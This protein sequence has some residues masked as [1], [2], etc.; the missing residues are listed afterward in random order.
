MN[1]F[2]V[3]FTICP[4]YL[5]AQQKLAKKQ[6]SKEKLQK[7]MNGIGSKENIAN[8]LGEKYD[9]SYN[10]SPALTVCL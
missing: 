8:P 5:S 9:Q 3:S 4:S 7:F 6:V 1:G 2:I 10:F